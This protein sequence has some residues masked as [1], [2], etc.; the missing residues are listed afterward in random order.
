MPDWT[1][2]MQ[3]TFEYY[4]VDSG[5]WKDDKM[6]RNI[7]GSSINRDISVETLGSASI[8]TTEAMG[9]CYIRKYLITVQNEITEKHPLDVVLVQTPSTSF[10]GKVSSISMDA[11]TPLIELKE[12]QPPI[13]YFITKGENIMEV[14]Y[15]LVRENAR[16]PVVSTKCDIT[17]SY[18]FVADPSDTW[19]SF[20]SALIANAKYELDLDNMGRILFSPKQDTASLQPVW[21]YDDSNS[22]ILAP[23]ITIDHD[24]YQVPN[25]VEVIYSNGIESLYSKVVNDDPNSPI[26]TINRG[27]EIPH[28][29]TDPSI[30]GNATQDQIDEYAERLLREMS[31]L[32]YTISY[33]HGY[34]PVR[35]NDCVRLNYSRAGLSGIK[36]KV[37]S[38]NIKCRP[39]C[40]VSEKAVFTV[41]LW[42]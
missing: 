31:T 32:E 14:A 37:I 36:A 34:C 3:Q 5:T 20:I 8:D 15:R 18:D 25:V 39:G 26:S 4:T 10:N 24:L 40:Q 23:D 38:Q 22:S 6:L 16:A 12:K 9:E 27:R 11:Y 1:K 13:G 42:R 28:R 30:V 17:L 19:L 21:T 35:V 2:S 33:T 29:V 41:K 7:K